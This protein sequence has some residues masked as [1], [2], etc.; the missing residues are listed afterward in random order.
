MDPVLWCVIAIAAAALLCAIL[1]PSAKKQKKAVKQTGEMGTYP[2]RFKEFTPVKGCG[3][4]AHEMREGYDAGV[5]M[6]KRREVEAGKKRRVAVPTTFAPVKEVFLDV[7]VLP[8]QRVELIGVL[9]FNEGHY[10][11]CALCQESWYGDR[12]PSGKCP[13]CGD[14]LIAVKSVEWLERAHLRMSRERLEHLLGNIQ[15]R[16]RERARCSC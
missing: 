7:K 3:C 15:Q 10:Q 9:D 5:A 11:R 14:E 2:V 12:I 4:A 1:W 16:A 8:K 13:K 6:V